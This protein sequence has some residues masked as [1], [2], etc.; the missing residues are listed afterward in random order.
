MRITRRAMAVVL[1][2]GLVIASCGSDDDADDDASRPTP[3]QPTTPPATDDTAPTDDTAATDTSE[4]D[5]GGGG[6]L[7]GGEGAVSI[8]AWAGY[9]ERGETDPAFDWVTEFEE[10]TGCMA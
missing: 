5:T 4:T 8:I 3:L 9:I 10:Q 6:E 7:E 1:L 2:G